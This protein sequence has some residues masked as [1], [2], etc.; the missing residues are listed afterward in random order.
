[1]VNLQI[2][3]VKLGIIRHDISKLIACLLFVAATTISAVVESAE[4]S[5]ASPS[6]GKLATVQEMIDA[7]TDVWGDE[8]MRQPD[9]ASYEFFKDLLPPLRWV[10][11]EFRHY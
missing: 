8:A 11:T 2:L 9:G 5:S 4:N 10:N 3:S 6:G 1:M 7:R